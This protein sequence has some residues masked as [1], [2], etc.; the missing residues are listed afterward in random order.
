VEAVLWVL[1]SAVDGI[2][3]SSEICISFGCAFF[4]FLQL[5]DVGIFYVVAF[6]IKLKEGLNFLSFIIIY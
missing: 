1:I 6:S 2:L 3:N 5:C 4:S